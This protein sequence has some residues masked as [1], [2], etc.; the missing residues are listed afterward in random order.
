[1]SPPEETF[2]VDAEINSTPGTRNHPLVPDPFE[3]R[4][5]QIYLAFVN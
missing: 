1:M 3:F 4:P 5:E 2:R